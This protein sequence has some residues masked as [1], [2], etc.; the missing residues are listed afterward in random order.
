ML[1]DHEGPGTLAA[2]GAGV[3]HDAKMARFPPELVEAKLELVPRETSPW[4]HAGVRLYA[5]RRPALSLS[6]V[7]GGATHYYDLETGR[8]RRGTL[9]DWRQFCT[10][11]DALP[12]NPQRRHN[13][14]RRRARGH[15]RSTQPADPLRMSA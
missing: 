12:Q 5:V 7:A 10:L 3:N 14:L 4:P 15:G 1:V 11:V 6:R 13:A 9:A 2:A 8:N